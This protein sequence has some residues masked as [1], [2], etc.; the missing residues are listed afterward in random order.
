MISEAK[1]KSIVKDV[2]AT[3]L[4]GSGLVTSDIN[5]DEDFDGEKIVRVTARLKSAPDKGERLHEAMDEIRDRLVRAGDHRFVF[6]RA[7]Y[8]GSAEEDAADEEMRG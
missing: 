2:L 1:V 5:F 4:A 8:L 7:D 3:T 6:I